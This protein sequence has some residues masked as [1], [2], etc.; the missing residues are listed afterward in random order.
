MILT[1][2]QDQKLDQLY[3]PFASKVEGFLVDA[4]AQGFNVGLFEGLRTYDRQ[5][6]LWLQGRDQSGN[7]VDPSKIVTKSPPG[8]SLHQYGLAVDIVFD[9]D[10]VKPGWQ[11][12]WDA[13]WPWKKLADLGQ[14]HGLEAAYYWKRFPEAPHFQ[15][16][17]GFKIHELLSLYLQGGLT[18]VWDEIDRVKKSTKES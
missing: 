9:A 7:V 6:E 14:S 13:K 12:S 10:A 5:K 18:H 16:S 8:M 17:F 11:W 4:K 1:P 15:C 3:L 2:D